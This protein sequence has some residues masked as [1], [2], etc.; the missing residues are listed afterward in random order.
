MSCGARL[1]V[2]ISTVWGVALRILAKNKFCCQ[3]CA[4]FLRSVDLLPTAHKAFDTLR[5][6][7]ARRNIDTDSYWQHTLRSCRQTQQL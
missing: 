5:I 6:I 7:K 4:N 1:G 3:T 2:D